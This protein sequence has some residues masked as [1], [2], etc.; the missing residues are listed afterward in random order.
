[1]RRRN[2]RHRPQ[3][4]ARRALDTQDFDPDLL[5][6]ETAPRGRHT[7]CSAA[8]RPFSLSTV[9]TSPQIKQKLASQKYDSFALQLG[10][11]GLIYSI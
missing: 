10:R 6:E 5:Q 2:K 8:Q 3:A 11:Q 4:F 1:M 9:A 7:R